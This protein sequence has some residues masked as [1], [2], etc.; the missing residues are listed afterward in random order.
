MV[1]PLLIPI[2]LIGL[3]VGRNLIEKD[4]KKTVKS[5]RKKGKQ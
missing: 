4:T 1:F 5:R 2:A 3:A